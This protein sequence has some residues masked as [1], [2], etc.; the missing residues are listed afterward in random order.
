MRLI[1][2]TIFLLVVSVCTAQIEVGA[3][4]TELYFPLLQQKQ[5]AVVANPTSVIG[6]THLVDTLISSGFQVKRIFGPEHGFR[7][8][9][10]NGDHVKDERDAKTGI[11][12]S[13]LYGKQVRPSKELLKNIDVLIFDMQDVGVRFYTY[14]STLHYIM[15]AA[16]ESKIKLI[17]LDR[18]NPN[19]HYIDGPVMKDSSLHSIVGM[20]PIPIVHGC[21][22]G[23]L[24]QMINEEG[25]LKSKM[26]CDLLVVPCKN[27]SHGVGYELPIAPS[28]NLKTATAILAYPSLCWFEGTVVS[29]GRGTEKPFER[30]GFPNFRGEEIVFCPKNIPGVSTNPP[31]MNQKCS[32][33]EI[34]R[35]EISRKN[36]DLKWLLDMYLAYP[37]K[38]RFFSSPNF[39]DKLAGTTVLRKQLIAGKSEQEIRNSWESDLNSYKLLRK[40]YLLY[41]DQN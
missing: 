15:E 38:E 33:I 21:T 20:H 39:F 28:P 17:V 26:K 4:N 34:G 22:F 5:I 23:E 18:P 36:L 2:S 27:Y 30:I 41:A 6:K 9:K 40:K 19:D 37:E 10:G 7:G 24:A 14:L 35:N 11:P 32:G 12:I 31:Y 3:E 25:W 8:N 16:A 29:V 1:I 13:S